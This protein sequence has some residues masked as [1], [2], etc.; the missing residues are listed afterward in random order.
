MSSVERLL[1]RRS[2]CGGMLSLPVMARMSM[3]QTH[4]ERPVVFWKTDPVGP[5]QTLLLFGDGLSDADVSAGRLAD[6]QPSLPGRVDISLPASS[7]KLSILQTDN[8]CLKVEIPKT[9]EPG[10]YV[11]RLETGTG[12]TEPIVVNH[13]EAYWLLGDLGD[14]A[15]AGAE[16]R[17]FGKNFR[18]GQE[19]TPWTGKA[20]LRDA[21]GTFHPLKVS[22]L[23][24]YTFAFQVPKNLAASQA[25]IFVHNGHG[26]AAGWS[27]PLALEIRQANPWPVTVFN[28]RDFGAK[29]DSSTDDTAV[30]RAA[31]AK[32]ETQGGG[33]VFLPRGIYSVTGQLTIPRRTVLRGENRELVWLVVPH[34]GPEFNTLLAGG[35]EFGVEELSMVARTPLR[36]IVA[37][38]VESMYSENKPWGLPGTSRVHDV[39]LRRLRVQHLRY[40]GRLGSE[41]PR[42][43]E[44]VGPSTIALAGS[45]LEIS[46]SEVV[47]SGMPFILHDL[48]SSRVSG[49]LLHTGRNGWYGFWGARKTLFEDNTI[50]GQD[51]E[52]SYGGFGNYNH[53]DG[54]DIS[55]I[56]I[57]ENKFLNGYGDEREA[58]TFDSPGDFPWK[59]RIAQAGASDLSVEGVAWQENAFRGLACMIAAGKGLGQHRRIVSNGA[60][61]L[62]LDAPWDVVPDASSVASIGPFR[63]DIVVYQN[64]S[65]DA[66]VGVQ[67]WGGGYNYI[68]DANST[69]RT[70]GFWGTGAEY[71]RPV[72]STQSQTFLPC[73]FTQWLNNTIKQPIAYNAQYDTGVNMWATLGLFTRDTLTA[74]EA[75][76]LIFGNLFR[77]NRLSDHS[78]I[79]L[80]Y[81]GTGARTNARK[82]LKNRPPV[83]LDNVIEGNI[84]SDAPVGIEV[85]PG[86]EGTL[87][88]NNQFERVDV[89]VRQGKW[90]DEGQ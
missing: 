68:I 64:D 55:H 15:T 66:S 30:I 11:V 83:G 22:S 18:M 13:P 47:S 9:W 8:R 73:Y 75:G 29:G 33:V 34:K 44:G 49:N 24:P 76:V 86:Y 65:Q 41:D 32:S 85:E 87:V 25:E 4:S 28:V 38:D 1:S 35:S 36:M 43:L 14:A 62:V 48:R 19:K 21:R 17:V 71:D 3:G 84:V 57:A 74:P 77:G 23:N 40:E 80:G 5:G 58:L 90:N 27:S 2:F 60:G 81:Y 54:T 26:G 31:L 20:V 89:P 37:P 42:R 63:R 82:A 70:G 46:N 51:M 59:G 72:S 67:L 6:V 88:R 10:S 69:V 50:Q 45:N 12:S 56:Y 7:A 61:R 53:Y 39:F 78:R 79:M 52:A 16:V